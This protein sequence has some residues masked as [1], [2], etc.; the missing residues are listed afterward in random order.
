MRTWNERSIVNLITNTFK[1]MGLVEESTPAPQ[2]AEA[3]EPEVYEWEVKR[4]A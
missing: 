4:S 1:D 2:T 3:A